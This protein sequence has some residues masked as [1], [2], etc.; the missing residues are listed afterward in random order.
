[1]E[2]EM[3][4]A[5]LASWEDSPVRPPVSL[6]VEVL[7]SVPFDVWVDERVFAS[8]P[9]RVLELLLVVLLSSVRA[10]GQESE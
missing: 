7:P 2:K 3:R 1:M 9:D 10:M 5:M 4:Q 6:R 8:V